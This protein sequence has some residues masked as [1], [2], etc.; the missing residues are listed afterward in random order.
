MKESPLRIS[1][2]SAEPS[3]DL[4]GAA[5]A[6]L[7]DGGIVAY[8]TETFYGLA[9]DALNPIGR[10]KVFEIK[11][12]DRTMPLPCIVADLKQLEQLVGVIPD[13]VYRASMQ[14][15]PGPVTLVIDVRPELQSILGGT[16]AVRISSLPVAREL[17]RLNGRPITSTSANQTSS[18]PSTT[19]DEVESC[20][21]GCVDLILDGG[22]TS[23]LAPTTIVEVTGHQPELLRQGAVPFEVVQA[24]LS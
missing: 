13:K 16:V 5:V 24:A 1:I 2:D 3:P 15:W 10:A 8:P 4:L 9:V 17:A 20:L 19:A 11:G 23:G 21:A 12:R 18:L 22:A 14:I 7:R 6:V